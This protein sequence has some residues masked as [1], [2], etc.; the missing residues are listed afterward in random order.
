MAKTS[1]APQTIEIT[2]FKPVRKG[3]L[4]AFF[5]AIVK[6]TKIHDCRIIKQKGQSWWVQGPQ[7]EYEKGG[8]RKF[9][10]VVAFSDDLRRLIENAVAAHFDREFGG[11]P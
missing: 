9:A 1:T 10:P 11:T 4:L 2:D 5:T 8:E 3:P 7:R 6:G